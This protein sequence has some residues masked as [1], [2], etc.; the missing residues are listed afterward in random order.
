MTFLFILLSFLFHVFPFTLFHHSSHCGG[1]YNYRLF[2]LLYSICAVC[3]PHI[4][5]TPLYMA[6]VTSCSHYHFYYCYYYHYYFIIFSCTSH[7]LCISLSV[8]WQCYHIMPIFVLFFCFFKF[9]IARIMHQG[10]LFSIGISC[11]LQKKRK[12]IIIITV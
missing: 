3:S 6:L 8:T 7:K 5:C 2:L 1:A 10:F 4:Y 9:Q 12:I 11:H